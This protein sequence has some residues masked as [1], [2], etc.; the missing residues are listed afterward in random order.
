MDLRTA[1]PV[2]FGQFQLLASLWRSPAGR[3]YGQTMSHKQPNPVWSLALIIV[4]SYRIGKA[5]FLLKGNYSLPKVFAHQCIIHC[6][7]NC[8]KEK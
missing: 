2:G 1:K 5:I 6:P 8:S 4:R 7:D 3:G